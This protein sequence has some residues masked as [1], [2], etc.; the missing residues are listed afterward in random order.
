MAFSRTRTKSPTECK[1][2]A[3]LALGGREIYVGSQLPARDLVKGG[4]RLG[5]VGRGH[6]GML[7]IG[8]AGKELESAISQLVHLGLYTP[9]VAEAIAAASTSA[10]P[11]ST[12]PDQRLTQ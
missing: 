1:W 6:D 3:V 9:A 2:V 12:F 11:T 7:L 8:Y 5:I 4:R 10:V